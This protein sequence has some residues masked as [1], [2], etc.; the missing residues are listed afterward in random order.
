ICG[1]PCDT[2]SRQ[3]RRALRGAVVIVTYA[4]IGAVLG[5]FMFYPG[6]LRGVVLGA[7]IGALI[8]AVQRLSGRVAELDRSLTSLRGFVSRYGVDAA[9]APAPDAQSAQHG[10][11]ETAVARAAGAS[12]NGPSAAT[13][14]TE[15]AAPT[16]DDV[17]AARASADTAT[18]VATER[19]LPSDA[20][21][22]TA[23]AAAAAGRKPP[24]A[25]SAPAVPHTPTL[26]DHAFQIVLRWLT[27]GN[28]A[29]KA[30]VIVSLFGMGFLIKE[31][32]DRGWLVLPVA[33]RLWL[34]AFVG[35]ALLA[36]GWRL[37]KRHRVYALS[38]QGGG[39]GMAY[40]PVYAR[41]AVFALLCQPLRFFLLV[42]VTGAAGAL[43]GLQDAKGR[44]VLGIVGGFLAPVLVG[45][46]M[47]NHVLLFGYYAVLN[48]AILGV[49]W[50]KAWR[51]LNVLGFGFTFVIG[52]LWGAQ[53]Y[54]PEHFATTD[55][56]LIFFT[57]LYTIVPILFALR[58]PPPRLRGF[59]DGTLVFGT[60]LVAFGLQGTL[61]GD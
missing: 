55:P 44:A 31:G 22:P 16:H 41:F 42:V 17:L 46:E 20:R 48:G 38:V 47:S 8:G 29:V 34:A 30:G 7:V 50:F 60:P 19:P 61:V 5:V 51:E 10:G 33:A 3:F 49:A 54:R 26:L 25:A 23:A 37:R 32:I 56:F 21:A 12:V 15:A 18:P 24:A 6:G 52:S 39:V 40:L 57:V 2:R 14:A 36:L 53:G 59:V 35:L 13:V 43:V 45:S 11:T 27:T 4:V 1:S 9:H 28:L 58:V